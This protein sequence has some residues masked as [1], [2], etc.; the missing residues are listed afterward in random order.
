MSR[1]FKV[2]VAALILAAGFAGSAAAGP[3][4]DGEAA[5][6]R[7]DYGSAIRLWR[8]LADQG[9]VGAQFNLGTMYDNGQ[10][11][12]PDHVAAVGWYRK[13]ADQ[14]DAQAQYNLGIMYDNGQGV[15]Q[16]YAVAA[17]WYRKAADQGDAQA[18]FNL[19]LMY[20]KGQGVPQDYIIAYMWSDLAAAQGVGSAAKNREIIARHMAP[21]QIAEAR[22]RALEKW[23]P[24][25][26]P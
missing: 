23:K 10:G 14:G 20:Y 22:Q 16:D 12:P 19:G 9:H 26:K 17:G 4:E 5:F 18:R 3:F 8:P 1:I 24:I 7:G 21:A 11:V 13:A 25:R 2:A 6:R 15:L